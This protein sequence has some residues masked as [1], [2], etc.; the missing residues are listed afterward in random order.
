MDCTLW[1]IWKSNYNVIYFAKCFCPSVFLDILLKNDTIFFEIIFGSIF[2]LLQHTELLN[3]YKFLRPCH[4]FW[5]ECIHFW[6]NKCIFTCIFHMTSMC[7]VIHFNKDFFS[8]SSR[9]WAIVS[10]NQKLYS[11][12][13]WFSWFLH[14][15]RILMIIP[16]LS[17]QKE[18]PQ[19]QLALQSMPTL[20][21][22]FNS[23]DYL[24]EKL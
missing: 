10:F 1:W 11:E 4:S 13:L 17:R 12:K 6:M 9:G 15:Q 20:N 2:S 5:N 14:L 18:M 8:L 16:T 22:D 24:L 19:F 7:I 21:F 3:C 23:V